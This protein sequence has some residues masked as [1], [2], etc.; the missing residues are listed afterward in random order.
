MDLSIT[1][2]VTPNV[3]M[4]PRNRLPF[5]HWQPMHVNLQQQQQQQG[6]SCRPPDDGNVLEGD[7][8]AKGTTLIRSLQI[9]FCGFVAWRT[10]GL[11]PQ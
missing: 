6:F 4:Y 10:E 1:W 5:T 9:R 11:V 3:H 7:T 2:H 8:R